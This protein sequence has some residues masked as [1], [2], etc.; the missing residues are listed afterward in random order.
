[1]DVATQLDPNTAPPTTECDVL[2][3]GGGPAG[4]T[5]A[6]LLAE[7]GRDV[8][9]VEKAQ[10]PRFHIGESLL[11]ANLPLFD[12]LGIAEEVRRIGLY[13]PGAEFVSDFYGKSNLFFFANASH[14]VATH[15][16][17]VRRAAFDQLLFDN[18]RR[19]GARTVEN[20]RVTDIALTGERPA[21]TAVGSD[22][23]T[24][25]W[26]PRFVVDA[27]GRDT[28]MANKLGLKTSNKRNN[29]AAIFGHFTGVPGRQGAAAGV[30]TVHLVEDGWF[31]MIPLPDGLMSVGLVGSPSLFKNRKE[32]IETLFWDSVRAAPSVAERMASA[33]LTAPLTTTGNYS[34]T[35]R[36]AQ[37]DRFLM[38][39]DALTFIDPIFSSGVMIA[40][41]SGIL[42]ADAI[43]LYLTDA[44]R[45]RQALRGF[46]R[47]IR[48]GVGQLS[49]MIYRINEPVMRHMLMHPSN[50]FRMR[51]GV[52]S[53][54]A[55][56]IFD[57]GLATR[58]P[59]MLFKLAYY[60]LTVRRWLERLGSKRSF[61][62]PDIAKPAA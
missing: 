41:T 51:D 47:A 29:T 14:L 54:L 58:G 56:E 1:M 34:Y 61:L 8:V 9:V 17:Q 12:R 55:G 52:I 43:D 4:S 28:V 38:I 37:G 32:G 30:I 15:S 57:S 49:W 36:S 33:E 6:A 16:Y 18:C 27:S 50:K 26:R 25:T 22:G 40:M 48:R 53:M 62:E 20:T 5:V 45:G 31:W 23:T 60:S 13:K 39:G 21:V 46:E 42:G 3:I 19:R 24:T 44:V 59:M 10:H 2:V 35:T 7:R 11:P